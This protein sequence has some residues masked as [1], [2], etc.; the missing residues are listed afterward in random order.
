MR[1]TMKSLLLWLIIVFLIFAEGEVSAQQE[2]TQSPKPSAS[3]PQSSPTPANQATPPDSPPG[4]PGSGQQE[5]DRD[6]PR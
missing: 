5:T 1:I 4:S 3:V 2:D 6:V